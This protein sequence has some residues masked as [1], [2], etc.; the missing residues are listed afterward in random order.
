MKDCQSPSP[1]LKMRQESPQMSPGVKSI[2]M[3]QRSELSAEKRLK[4]LDALTA[5]ADFV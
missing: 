4:T 3:T 1:G 5:L 2:Q